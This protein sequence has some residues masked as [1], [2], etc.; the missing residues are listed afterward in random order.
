MCGIFSVI[1]NSNTYTP[2]YLKDVLESVAK[3]SEVRGVDSSG[4]CYIDDQK[5]QIKVTKGPVK[6]STLFSK[7]GV[8]S[9]ISPINENVYFAFGHTRLVTNGSQLSDEN[10]QPVIKDGIVGVHNGIIVNDSEIW[11]Q[12]PDLERK[13]EIDTEVLISL[14]NKNL[15]SGRCLSDSLKVVEEAVYG[16]LSVA[17]LFDDKNEFMVY[18]NYGSFYILTDSKTLFVLASEKNILNRLQNKFKKLNDD[19]IF[20]MKQI[21]PLT[22]YLI[23]IDCFKVNHFDLNSGVKFDLTKSNQK[24]E[25]EIKNIHSDK[26]QI[27]AVVD[28]EK[29]RL[30][31]AFE[32]ERDLLEYN[33]DRISKLKRCTK[34][35]LPETFPFIEFDQNGVCNYCKH[36]KIKNQPKPIEELF[37]L[38]EPYRKKNGEP[39][40]LIPFS[41]GRDSTF[42]L[43]LVKKVLGLNPIAFTYDWGMVTDLARRN[44][45]R[46]CG[47]LGVEHIIVSA[48]IKWKRDNIKKN[49]L[50]WLKKPHLGM[51]PL[52][53]AGDKYFYYHASQVKK[54]NDI[55]IINNIQM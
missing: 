13:F 23:N 31:P 5:Q 8:T 47:S 35:I 1:A 49:I 16:T 42:A 30:N 10:N 51:V 26:D 52:F 40:V 39:D 12:N 55:I 33:I 34:C 7:T 2:K 32:K 17:L 6:I 22:G 37:K 53:M 11:N 3:Y 41:G 45:A 44:I 4:I 27:P 14:L 43:H 20:T 48:D 19:A 15:A 9:Q 25:I 38:V 29:F 18:S 46:L 50:A 54:Q 21:T 36:Y 28:P 24:L